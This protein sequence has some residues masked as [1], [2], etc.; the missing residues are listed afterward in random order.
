ML[1]V[2]KK[3]IISIKMLCL[4]NRRMGVSLNSHN[5]VKMK[6]LK[7]MKKLELK[8]RIKVRG[9]LRKMTKN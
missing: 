4:M 3:M 7:I 6:I 9:N 5:R 2:L 1:I 8:I